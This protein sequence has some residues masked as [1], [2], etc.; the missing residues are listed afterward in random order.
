[1][2]YPEPKLLALIHL[3]IDMFTFRVPI[4]GDKKAAGHGRQKVSRGGRKRGTK[5]EGNRAGLESKKGRQQDGRTCGRTGEVRMSEAQIPTKRH[6]PLFKCRILN[7]NNR[8]EGTMIFVNQ[9]REANSSAR[10]PLFPILVG[11]RERIRRRRNVD[12][13]R[14]ALSLFSTF[15]RDVRQ[16]QRDRKE[17]KR[18]KKEE[19]TGR[20]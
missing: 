20:E 9:S 12:G 13:G 8:N 1:M 19:R 3:A 14:N 5:V 4:Q 10:P 17:R 2:P 15:T 7:T 11:G 6:R 18:R 16:T